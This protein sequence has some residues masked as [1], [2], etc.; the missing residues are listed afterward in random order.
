M[1]GSKF[2]TFGILG[3]LAAIVLVIVSL[4]IDP[5]VTVVIYTVLAWL[6]TLLVILICDPFGTQ[7]SK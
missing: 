6:N 4:I 7:S 2:E 3:G 1:F 5:S